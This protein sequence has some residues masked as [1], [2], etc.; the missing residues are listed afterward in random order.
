MTLTGRILLLVLL[1]LAPA[2]AVQVYNEQ[3]LRESRSDAVRAA[4]LRGAQA[5]A[6]DLADFADGA[7]QTLDILA[8]EPVIRN[9][10][11]AAC[12]PFLRAVAG[13]ISGSRIIVVTDREGNLVCNSRGAA[14]GAYSLADRAYFKRVMATGRSAVGEYVI[15]RGT[16]LP[17]IQFAHPLRDPSD[18]IVGLI[19]LGFDPDWLG[20]RL[21]TAGLPRD[22]TVTV[23]D[24]NGIVLV[25][26]PDTET[27][28]GRAVPKAFADGLERAAAGGGVWELQGLLGDRRITGL[29]RPDGALD[30]LTVVVGLSREL[31]FADIDAATKRGAVLI[32]LGTLIAVLAALWGGRRFIRRPV[33]QLLDAAG[34]WS[35][36]DLSVRS[37]LTGPSEFGKLG[38]AFDR[39]AADLQHHEESLKAE[40]AK[41]RALQEQQITMLHE[42]NHRVKNT[43][44]TVQSLA[45]QSRGGEEQVVQL[46][47]RI[48]ALSKTHDLLT[49]RD[50]TRAP[51]RQ[52]LE[53]E[54][55]PYRSGADHVTLTGEELELPPR[56]VLALGMTAHELTTN[57][58]KYGA[59]STE[60]GR[61]SVAW[62]VSRGE[63]GRERLHIEWR[64]TGGPPV[65]QPRRR[66][67]GSR[68][69]TG[70]IARELDGDVRLDF[71]PDGLRCIID[72]P[73]ER[74]AAPPIAF[75]GASRR[76]AT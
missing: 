12:T 33:R 74:E 3:A 67:F 7:R 75:L 58:A 4:A 76:T 69:I 16:G 17:T 11:A 24:H 6:A 52:V 72:V 50:W 21:G 25:R 40:L 64:E 32:A 26:L 34:A 51:L 18:D 9:R 71:A 1:A 38:R 5:V 28:L 45:R 70:G 43:L 63:S 60:A 48:L 62:R 53:N 35:A 8:E 73:L 19:A 49:R 47:N 59:L 22:A 15:S 42:L 66:G 13:R 57:A 41:S 54:L 2:V 14:P 55:S 56:Y 39:M 65:S 31:A 68:L 23:T 44:A 37:G 46:E 36:G 27:W 29:V 61:V 30:G 20:R 10:E